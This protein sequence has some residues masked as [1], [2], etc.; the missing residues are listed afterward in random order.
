M[1]NSRLQKVARLIQKDMGD[2]LRIEAK[3]LF[4]GAMISVTKVTV[5]TDLAVA[6]LYVS[7]LPLGQ[8][9]IEQV[10]LLIQKNKKTLRN[11]LAQRI[12]H[13]LRIIPNLSFFI[14]DSLDYAENIE[15]L[16]KQK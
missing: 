3:N 7:I 10:L 6:K 13:Q 9:S 1:E 16:L 2:I 4:C 15:K 14:D 11:A 12:K 8:I 5:S